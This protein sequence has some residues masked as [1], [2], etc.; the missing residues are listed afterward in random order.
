MNTIVTQIGHPNLVSMK[1]IQQQY[2]EIEKFGHSNELE[3]L[4][5][6]TGKDNLKTG[7]LIDGFSFL[8][9]S[10]MILNYR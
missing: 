7:D 1:P 9:V 2:K 8:Q 3:W 6:A 10:T 5:K 4:S